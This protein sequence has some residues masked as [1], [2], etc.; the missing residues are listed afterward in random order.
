MG[1]ILIVE[2]QVEIRE[3]LIKKAQEMNPSVQ[4]WGTGSARE[5]LAFA[6]TNEVEAFFLDIQLEDYN[7]LELAKQ[8]RDIKRYMFTPLVF[9]TAMPTREIEA[10]K[11]THCYDY[12]IKPFTDAQIE[13]VFQKILLDYC[14]SVTEK[15]NSK[16]ILEFKTHN[17]LIDFDDIVYVE[18]AGRK[19]VI[20]TKTQVIPYKHMALVKFIEKLPDYF[21][22]IH[23]AI[24]VNPKYIQKTDM[25][26]ATVELKI[27]NQKL[28]IGRSFLKKVEVKLHELF[29]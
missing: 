28:P 20:Y 23:Q 5:A 22:H 14:A 7:G 18:Y 12:I 11:Q 16:L 27:L 13:E 15:K 2:D 21:M 29:E 24:I 17:Q 26:S 4:I 8:L 3:M 10:F 25:K 6:Q 1:K 9:I 19:V